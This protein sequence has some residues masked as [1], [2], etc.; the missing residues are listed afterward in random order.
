MIACILNIPHGAPRNARCSGFLFQHLAVVD[1]RVANLD[2]ARKQ[3]VEFRKPG[4]GRIPMGMMRVLVVLARIR[5]RRHSNGS[6]N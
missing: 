3:V 2:M 5:S 4:G 6:K 1:I